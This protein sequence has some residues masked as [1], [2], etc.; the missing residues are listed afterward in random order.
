MYYEAFLFE[1]RSKMK[2]ENLYKLFLKYPNISIDSRKVNSKSIF[3]A[4]K[5]KRF[6]GNTFTKKALTKCNLAIIDNKNYFIDERTILVNNTLLTLHELANYHRKKLGIKIIALTGTNGKT[7]TKEL[8]SAVLSEKYNVTATQ[9]NLN[10]HIG[11][12]LTLLNMTNKTEIGVVEMG[13]NHIKEI[14]TLCQIAEPNYGLITNIG[15]AHLEGFGTYENIIKAKSE[16]YEYLINT[17]GI[18]FQNASNNLLKKLS[19]SYKTITYRTNNFETNS[20]AEKHEKMFLSFKYKNAAINT[21]L[22]GDY[23]YENVMA[24]VGIGEYFDLPF[25]KIIT[26]INKY[27]PSNLRSQLVK[28]RNNN[29]ILDA[30]NANPSSMKYS[31]ENF[32]NLKIES[33]V[34]ILGDMFELGNMAVIKHKKILNYLQENA[35]EKVY[36]VGKE[37]Y[38]FIDQFDYNFFKETGELYEYFKKNKT[39]NKNILIKGSRGMQLEQLVELL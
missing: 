22:I 15:H 3:I 37:F 35:Y 31:I 19:G 29:L 10:N 18:I 12:P 16:L 26:A 1:R 32:N 36:L 25:E 5:G 17:H 8:I 4:L 7:T 39:I 33:K 21:N 27:K 6:D 34:L 13:A 20:I 14:E 28:T 2:I 11:V 38:R 24:A 30:Y 23:N 9:G